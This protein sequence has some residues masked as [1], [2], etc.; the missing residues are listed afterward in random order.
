MTSAIKVGLLVA[1]A[2]VFPM[3]V[4]LGT[5]AFY[6]SPRMSEKCESMMR[7]E[8]S[9]EP[10]ESE[11]AAINKC[12][13][14]FMKKMETYNRNIFIPITIIGFLALAAGAL[15]ISEAMGPVAPGLVFGGVLTILYASMRGFTA[16][17]KRWLFI[18]LVIVLIGLIL[19]TRRFLS[20]T[21]AKK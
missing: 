10:T 14:D 18:E 4:G 13:D 17:D 1:V 21:K 5:E 11:Q 12:E 8:D 19:V 16:V 6:P 7:L 9:G 3:M 20:Q 2:I 15:F